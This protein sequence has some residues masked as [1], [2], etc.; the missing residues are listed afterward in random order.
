MQ[1]DDIYESSFDYKEVGRNIKKFRTAAGLS[2]AK[3]AEAVHISIKHLSKIENGHYKSHFHNFVEI[4][5]VLG[6]SLY[7]LI[8]NQ[9][10]QNTDAAFGVLISEK[11]KDCT[12]YQKQIIADFIDFIKEHGEPPI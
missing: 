10:L 9:N 11:S 3:L 1:K 7:D 4:A 6:V 2:Q 12:T 5:E 8:G